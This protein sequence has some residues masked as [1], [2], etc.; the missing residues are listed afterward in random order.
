MSTQDEINAHQ[1]GIAPRPQSETSKTGGQIAELAGA[2][3]SIAEL[4]QRSEQRQNAAMQQLQDRVDQLAQQTNRASTTIPTAFRGPF[5]QLE[6]AMAQLADRIAASAPPQS[7]SASWHAPAEASIATTEAEVDVAAQSVAIS[8]EGELSAAVHQSDALQ[9]LASM[10]AGETKPQGFAAEQTLADTQDDA[11]G[12]AGG[13]EPSGA[14]APAGDAEAAVDQDAG[15]T[16]G[17]AAF[18]AE[19]ADSAAAQIDASDDG[20]APL[21]VLCDPADPWDETTAE[22]LTRHYETGEAGL[23]V[24]A[25]GPIDTVPASRED[26]VAEPAELPVVNAMIGDL[27]RDWISEQFSELSR[28]LANQP[29][30][31]PETDRHWITQQFASITSGIEEGLAATEGQALSFDA[32][33]ERLSVLEDRIEGAIE[34]FTNGQDSQ[35]LKEIEACIVEFSSQLERS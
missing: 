12:D 29:R 6:E 3:T 17:P 5:A 23:P 2:L 27:D 16:T 22:Q 10:L 26:V 7:V 33:D 1:A 25:D 32:F 31:I 28:I 35:E 9:A 4:M 34:A 24:F 8:G 21:T 13:A 15:G 18:A 11:A 30:N 20:L 14:S 19:A